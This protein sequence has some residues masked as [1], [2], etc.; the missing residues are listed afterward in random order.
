MDEE[1]EAGESGGSEL[2]RWYWWHERSRVGDAYASSGCGEVP[3]L[4]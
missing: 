3:H 2:K 1:E 4:D